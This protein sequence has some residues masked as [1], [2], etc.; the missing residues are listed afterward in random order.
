MAG[1]AEG[2]RD[3]SATGRRGVV[4]ESALRVV[5][6][7]GLSAASVAAGV[8]GTLAGALVL[9]LVLVLVRTPRGRRFERGAPKKKAA[10]SER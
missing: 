7:A 4:P 10:V 1:G 2:R 6:A 8:T 5:F 3:G 9:V